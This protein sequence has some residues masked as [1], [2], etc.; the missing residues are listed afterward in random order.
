MSSGSQ[1]VIPEGSRCPLITIHHSKL[2][3]DS[4]PSMPVL[5]SPPAVA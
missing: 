1:D 3:A 2:D 5:V 4:T